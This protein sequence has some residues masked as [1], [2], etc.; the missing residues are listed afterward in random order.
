MSKKKKPKSTT[1]LSP[2]LLSPKIPTKP[3]ILPIKHFLAISLIATVAFSAYANT[4]YVPFQFD[5]RPNISENHDIQIKTFAFNRL[6][7]LARNTYKETIRI[8]AY[9]TFTLN[10][11]FGG[12]DVFGYH[13]VN[14]LIHIASGII[15]YWLLFLTLNLP[16]LPS[17]LTPPASIWIT[18]SRSQKGSLILP[19]P[20]SPFSSSLVLLVIVSGQRRRSPCSPSLSSGTLVIW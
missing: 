18:I 20:C 9:F 12:L 5:D 10:Y 17:T 3:Y 19:Q 11:Y 6:E 2:I 1:F 16:P 13:L 7:Q 15:F 4:F 14:L 8:F